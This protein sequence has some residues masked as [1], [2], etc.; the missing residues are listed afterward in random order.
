MSVPGLSVAVTIGGVSEL[1]HELRGNI[2]GTATENCA[3][4]WRGWVGDI[5]TAGRGATTARRM[6][7]QI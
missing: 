4:P 6:K 5:A 3:L 1:T 2:L 7:V